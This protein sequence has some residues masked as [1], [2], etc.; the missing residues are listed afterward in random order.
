MKAC[1][2]PGCVSLAPCPVHTRQLTGK[3]CDHCAATGT[4]LDH[5]GH[6]FACPV[7]AGCG[8]IDYK[9]RGPHARAKKGPVDARGLIVAQRD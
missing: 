3:P 5:T 6:R 7:C 4:V 2:Y 8:L 9:Q 1:T